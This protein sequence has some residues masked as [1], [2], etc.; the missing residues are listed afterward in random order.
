MKEQILE[1]IELPS[2][3]LCEYEGKMFKCRKGHI[4]LARLIYSPRI[5]IA[6]RDGS[7]ILNCERGNKIEKKTIKSFMAHIKNILKGLDEKFIYVLE[8]CNVHFPMTFRVEGNKFVIDNFLGEKTSRYAEILPNVEIK[9]KG[10]EIRV[11]SSDKES[12]GQTSGNFE[13]VTK[14]KGRDRRI[15]QDGIYIV[16]KP[17]DKL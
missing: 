13:K 10:Q 7:V 17:G 5:N 6:I 3:V 11:I 8:A 2:G 12:A 16:R 4:E 14:I 1:K 15:F 9:I